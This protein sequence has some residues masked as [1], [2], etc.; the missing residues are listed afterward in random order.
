MHWVGYDQVYKQ[1][2][3]TQEINLNQL[4]NYWELWDALALMFK[5]EGQ[6]D[7]NLGWRVMYKDNK[8]KLGLVG[9]NPWEYVTLLF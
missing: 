9:H 7:R 3:I 5:L 2:S 8:D 6:L 4:S 1:G